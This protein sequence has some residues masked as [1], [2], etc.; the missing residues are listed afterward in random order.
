MKVGPK[1]YG[2]LCRARLL[3]LV[4]ENG[5]DPLLL[6][7]LVDEVGFDVVPKAVEDDVCPN[8]QGALHP[9]ELPGVCCAQVAGRRRRSKVEEAIGA[10]RAPLGEKLE[11]ADLD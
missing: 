3:A 5:I 4:P 7:M 9:T 8:S 11:K 6:D 2:P 10:G 1:P